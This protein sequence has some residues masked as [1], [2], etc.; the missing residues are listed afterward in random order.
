MRNA[1][2]LWAKIAAAYMNVTETISTTR[3]WGCV[4]ATPSFM[5]AAIFRQGFYGL[6]LPPPLVFAATKANGAVNEPRL[7]EY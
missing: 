2:S 3:T 4:P 7:A 6:F 1:S 5:Q